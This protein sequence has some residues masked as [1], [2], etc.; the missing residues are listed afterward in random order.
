MA[1]KCGWP[2]GDGDIAGEWAG[3][4]R[5]LERVGIRRR[6]GLERRGNE[7]VREDNDWR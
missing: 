1:Q 5:I 4:A 3:A 7:G 6:E 2:I